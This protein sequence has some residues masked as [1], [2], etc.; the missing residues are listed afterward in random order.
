MGLGLGE[1]GAVLLAQY[2]QLPV[3]QYALLA[4]GDPPGIVAQQLLH[5]PGPSGVDGIDDECDVAQEMRTAEPVGAVVVAQVGCMAIVDDHVSVLWNEA[6]IVYRLPPAFSVQELEGDLAGRVDVDPGLFLL[7]PQRGLI[8]VHGGHGEQI[9]PGTGLPP[10]ESLVDSREEA[11]EGGFGELLADH[12]GQALDGA[13]ERDHLHELVDCEDPDADAVLTRTVEVV[14]EGGAGL[15]VAVRAVPDLGVVVLDDLLEDDVDAG[16]PL[17]VGRLGAGQ[18]L[19]A[20]LAG[21]GLVHM[22]LLAGAGARGA[23]WDLLTFL[24]VAATAGRIPVAVGLRGRDG[25]VAAGPGRQLLEQDRRDQL[26]Q[27]VLIGD[28]GPVFGQLRLGCL[29]QR[30]TARLQLF[31]RVA[32]RCPVHRGHEWSY[33]SASTAM[34]AAST[35]RRSERGI[36]A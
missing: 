7:H 14:G 5:A 31:E 15:A 34:I 36:P 24:A 23:F 33:S 9:L 3:G 12:G 1:D 20:V 17:V 26:E 13:P 28:Q 18:L 16:A 10:R 32:Q 25:G 21:V 6:D 19:A 30:C 22:V 27:R 4:F 8:D 2:P 11:E 29:M 35:A